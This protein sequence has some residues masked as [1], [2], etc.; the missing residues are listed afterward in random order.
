MESESKCL[1]VCGGCL[2]SL[3]CLYLCIF[4]FVFL[5]F[6]ISIYHSS[7]YFIPFFV[8]FSIFIPFLYYTYYL[9]I[10]LRRISNILLSHRVTNAIF[11]LFRSISAISLC[12]SFIIVNC[13][14]VI[15][16]YYFYLTTTTF[17]V[18]VLFCL[19]IIFF[20]FLFY[21]LMLWKIYLH[22]N[23]LFKMFFVEPVISR[24]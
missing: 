15:I 20:I 17:M 24:K 1:L 4:F 23:Q 2:T 11:L 5:C 22:K 10:F 6:Y 12:L 18:I 8:F 16:Y 9:F 21:S 14:I 13:I 19:C 3:C 7:L